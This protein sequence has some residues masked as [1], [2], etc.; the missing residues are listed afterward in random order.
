[1]E[2]Q[3][4]ELEIFNQAKNWKAYFSKQILPFIWGDV[5]EVGAGIG[6]N[7]PY[8]YNENVKS[9]TSLEP[10]TKFVSKI[11][12]TYPH[13]QVVEGTLDALKEKKYDTVL[14]LDVLEHISD[15]NEEFKKAAN[16]VRPSGNLII[17]CPAHNYLF[18]PFDQAIGHY[19]RYNKSMYKMLVSDS[20]ELVKLRYLDSLGLTLSLGNSLILK[21]SMPTLKQV[22]FWDK[23][24]IPISRILDPLVAYLFGKAIVGVWRKKSDKKT[25]VN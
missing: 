9:W 13:I 14:Y 4:N 3:G 15:D 25:S 23:V 7:I 24:I 11:K 19:R 8:L 20:L 2:Y 10:D 16:M 1:M 17:Q 18:S 6:A 5:L 21:S 22:L 12:E